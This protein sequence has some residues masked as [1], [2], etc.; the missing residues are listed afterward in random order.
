ML[1]GQYVLRKQ[2]HNQIGEFG[3]CRRRIDFLILW[4]AQM[5]SY[6]GF[7]YQTLYYDILLADSSNLGPITFQN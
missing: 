2:Y 5:V 1:S 7:R 4:I 3:A 6:G